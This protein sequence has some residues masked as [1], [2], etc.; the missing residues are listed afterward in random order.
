M[1]ENGHRETVLNLLKNLDG[2]EPLKQLFWSELNYERVNKPISQRNWSDTAREALTEPPLLFAAGG[3]DEAFKVIYSQLA[4]DKLLKTRE[5]P[6][7]NALLQEYEY[8]LFVFSN[9]NQDQWHF[10]NVKNIGEERKKRDEDKRRRFFRRITVGPGERLRTACER[11][12][13]L[14]L[15]DIHPDLFGLSP[16]AIQNRHDEAFNVEAVT[17]QFYK[18][19]REIFEALQRKLSA[20]TDDAK[21]AHDYSLQFINRLMFLYFIQRKGWLGDDP[22]FLRNFWEAYKDSK[23]KKDNFFEKWLK[24]LFFEA[25]NNKFHGGHKHF[26][27]DIK[28]ALQMAP[29]L[30]GG[31]FE[32]NDLDKKHNAEISDEDFHKIFNFLEGYN[33]T[34]S[35]DSPLDQEVAVDPEMIGSV[36][37]NMVNVSEEF[38][39]RGEGGIFYTH[40]TEIELMCRLSLVDNLANRIG[41]KHKT[42]LYELV[43]AFEP[44]EKTAADAEIEK[45]GLWE[46]VSNALKST[47]VLDPAC[48]SGSFLVGMLRVIDDLSERANEALGIEETPY[49]RRKRIIRES[50]YGV[51]VVQW[52]VDIAE[53]RLWLQLVVETRLEKA[54]LKFRP[55]LPNLTFKIRRGDSLVQEVGGINLGHIKRNIGLSNELKGKITRLKAEKQKFFNNDPKAKYKR[56]SQLEAEELNLFRVILAAREHE[57]KERI[58]LLKRKIEGP[59]ETQIRLDGTEEK[60]PHQV[61]NE[62]RDLEVELERVQRAQKALKTTK[63]IP[64]VWD[65]S[66]VEIFEG[67]KSG[68][69]IVIGNPPYVRQENIADPN[70]ARSEVT[71]E[72]KKK[73]K[74]KLARSIYQAFPVFFKYDFY[75]DKAAYKMKS[76]G[77]L[78]IYFYFHGLSVLNR[79][80][81]FCFITSNSWLD[82][83]YGQYLQEF[84]LKHAHVKMIIDNRAKRSFASAEVNTVIALFSA[85]DEKSSQGLDK[86]ARFVMFHVPFDEVLSPVIFEEIEEAGDKNSTPDYRVFPVRQEELLMEGLE[87]KD[88]EKG[89]SSP[90]PRGPLIK[91]AKYIGN[92]WGGKY[93][94]APEIYWTILEKGKDK[95]VR[96]GDVAEVRR[97]ITTGANEFF[98]LDEEK[99]KEWGIEEEFLKT[100]IVSPRES[101]S[102]EIK[103]EE[104]PNKAFICHKEKS[105]LQGTNALSYIKWGEKQQFHTRPSCRGR[106]RWYE[107]P[108]KKWANILWP[109]IHNERHCVFWNKYNVV[110]DHNLF[111]IF[112]HN[113]NLIWG[114]L[115]WSAQILFRE[116]HGRVNLG[117]GALKT[118]GIDI[119]TLY[120]LNLNNHSTSEKIQNIPNAFFKSRIKSIAEELE[121]PERRS[122]D[123]IIFDALGLTKGE[124][125][126]VYEA[127]VEL[128]E[129]RLKKAKSV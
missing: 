26:P 22:E 41:G 27:D 68:F 12:S 93:L 59:S 28:Q 58:K 5:R 56:Q 43:F 48:G 47:T 11:I 61:E 86:N 85:S 24:V 53:L 112:G 105:K 16:L 38:D 2:L 75:K 113:E 97:G 127:V 6:V 63:D 42:E 116:L 46:T 25:F 30:N 62:V 90:K 70:L 101:K 18:H 45:K 73:Y 83:G 74:E 39:D 34:I 1:P 91:T 69:D 4:S 13:M 67:D 9:E 50:L 104:L 51:D 124:R 10:V 77:D 20:R 92:K 108:E 33:F 111:E 29:F 76:T 84:L 32:E 44:D 54:E 65:I 15:A 115:F 40:R 118:E 57:I 106:V 89:K 99:I 114:S 35:E 7:I 95:L 120:V 122:F 125:E 82:V 8:A 55:L 102:I 31:L 60:K 71:P 96:L 107:F 52:A 94:R 14:D 72:N 23:Q 64:F 37:E 121:N 110:V 109:M 88:E 129:W 128:V 78:Y 100:V 36:Y 19:Y 87:T 98:Y 21:W 80:G 3:E 117:Q 49:E 103:P 123:D 119:K 66:F 79:Q 126:A 17:Q 81:S